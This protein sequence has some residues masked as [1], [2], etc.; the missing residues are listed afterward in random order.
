MMT[1]KLGLVLTATV[2]LTA[3][4]SLLLSTTAPPVYYQLQYAP[5]E[6]ECARGF[7]QGVRV[8]D[9]STAHPFDRTDMVVVKGRGE[10][11]Y[12]SSYQWVAN[13]GTMVAQDLL[14][15]LT[16]GALF[17]QVVSG[18]SPLTVPLELTGRVFVFGWEKSGPQARAVLQV[19]VSLTDTTAQ[20]VLFRRTYT[21]ES[22]PFKEDTSSEFARAMDGLAGEFSGRLRRDLCSGPNP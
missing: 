11:L 10:V 18:E 7:D 21:L 4:S 2:F 3:C 9:F 15:D 17:P 5:E 14:R 12:S 19:E 6:V 22:Q 1:R 8:W 16:L 20:K 13:P